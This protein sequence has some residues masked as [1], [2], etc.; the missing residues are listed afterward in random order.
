MIKHRPL[1]IPYEDYV[2]RQGGKARNRRDDL[3]KGK[4]GSLRS[5]ELFFQQARRHLR[6][7]P[8]LCLGARTGAEVEAALHAGLKG[9]KGID[10]HPV[11][12]DVIQG[13]W[14]AIPFP[15]G[16]FA[17]AFTN[18]LDHCQDIDKL[19]AETARIL[20]PGGS[21]FVMAT[22]REPRKSY[23]QWLQK[24]PG[25]FLFWDH[26]SHLRDGIA[27]RGFSAFAEWRSGKWGCYILRRTP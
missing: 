27:E 2:Y 26:S 25:E 15:D 10:L 22:D 8:M 18:S 21:F 4:P 1:D 23:E 12:K 20:Q 9:S 24:C 5:F 19:C 7:G 6:D 11:S 3:M 13:D 16:A 17:N 14:H